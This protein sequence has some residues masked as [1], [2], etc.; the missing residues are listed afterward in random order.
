MQYCA[1]IILPAAAV[2][3]IK[4]RC[5]SYFFEQ[6]RVAEFGGTFIMHSSVKLQGHRHSG[7]ILRFGEV[8]WKDLTIWVSHLNINYEDMKFG[9][10]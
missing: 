2:W 5:N 7:G 3:S 1:E 4:R 8:V 9:G 6:M 10:V